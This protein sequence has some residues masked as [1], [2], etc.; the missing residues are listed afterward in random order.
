MTA[1]RDQPTLAFIYDRSTSD[2]RGLL[3]HRL[4]VCQEYAAERRWDV[5]G[6]WI[7]RGDTAL[8]GAQRPQM[9]ALLRTLAEATRTGRD[10]GSGER[11]GAGHGIPPGS[12]RAVVVPGQEDH[13]RD[14]RGP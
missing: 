4:A 12:C 14:R 11:A 9:S 13:I 10:G 6:E 1:P 8:T 7:D 5:A 3:A 2:Y